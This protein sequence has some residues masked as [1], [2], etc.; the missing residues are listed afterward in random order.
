MVASMTLKIAVF[1][2][3]PSASVKTATDVNPGRFTSVRRPVSKVLDEAFNGVYP[4]HVTALLLDL[5]QPTQLAQGPVTSLFC[6]YALREV[7]LNL[8]LEVK[9]QFVTEVLLDPALPEQ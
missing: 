4:A 9:T 8:L 5:V 6:R 1:A 3:M 2:P 7:F